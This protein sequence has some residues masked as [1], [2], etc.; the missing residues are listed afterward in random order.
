L[1]VIVTFKKIHSKAKDP[2]EA[3]DRPACYDLYITEDITIPSG[4]WRELPTGIIFAP[5]PH[6]YIKFL[7]LSLTP[8]GNVATRIHTRS[9]LAQRG[10][11]AHLGIIDNDYRGE[12]T[13]IMFNHNTY[14]VRYHVGDKIG[15]VEFY[16]VPKVIFWQ[17]KRLSNSRRGNRGFGSSGK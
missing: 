3:Y 13:I 14:P 11:R 6:I 5:W 12:I 9:S 10:Q 17:K 16:K 2:S 8:F 1:P 15:P 7:N 4:Q